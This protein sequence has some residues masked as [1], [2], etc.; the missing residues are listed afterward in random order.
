MKFC[1]F[2]SNLNGERPLSCCQHETKLVVGNAV[3]SQPGKVSLRWRKTPV[4]RGVKQL[5]IVSAASAETSAPKST[6]KQSSSVVGSGIRL[7]DVAVTFKNHQVLKN[8]SWDVKKG[9]RVGLVGVNGAGKTTQLQVITGA[10]LPD[11][12]EVIKAR[13]NMKI[14]Y[15]TQEFDVEP[16]RTVREEFM[17]AFSDQLG[18]MKRQEEVQKGLEECGDDMD[19][20]GQLLDELNELSKVA[21]DLDVNLLDKKIDQMMPELG[22]SLDDNDRLVA[23]YSG[24]WQMRMCLGKI[25]LQEPDLL[26]LDEPTNHLDLDAIGWLESYL[27]E[28]EVPMVIVSH[29][30][31][32]LDALCTKIVET[33]RGVT[34][35]FKGNYSDY[36][37]QKK[38]RVAQQWTAWE[39]QEKELDRQRE[40]VRSLAAGANSGR[41]STAEKAIE[42]M[43]A[44]GTYVEKPFVPRK[45][46]FTF[47][48]AERMGRIAIKIDG[49][50]HG[51]HGRNLF[52]DASLE[53]EKGE[54]VAI[55]GPNGAGKSTL[56]RLIMGQE[57]PIEGEVSMGEHGIVAN[58][59][60]QNQAEALDP[61]KNAIETLQYA[62]PDAKLNDVKALLGKMMFNGAAMEKKAKVLSGGEKARLAMAK[63]MLTEGT[64][65]ILDEP[66]NH[67]DIPTKE[68]LEEAVEQFDGAVIAVSHDRYFLRKIA[69]RVVT[70]ENGKLVDYDGDYNTFLSEN[71]SEKKKMDKLE[72][73]EREAEKSKV[74]AKSK[75]SK[76]QKAALKKEKAK[77]FN[78]TSENKKASKAKN[79]K[80]WN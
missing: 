33:E 28:Q 38:E 3:R 14:A 47:P 68:T 39:K 79:N 76:A 69:T 31:Q 9:E 30:R 37:T 55:I 41:A 16:T 73:R 67:L 62:S 17:S 56:L 7:E 27:K 26:L 58:Y 20:M 25:L 21:V 12:G 54:R 24:G 34:Q 49:L 59:F 13:Q 1:N 2:I 35:T 57:D 61:E 66:T 22:F 40:I 42:K 5:H 43:K 80:R 72:Q 23:S 8:A 29:D 75:M 44:E 4:Q 74:K 48:S 50:T 19:K 46:S 32:F 78:D 6:S 11:S 18:V 45:R 53:I 36:Q 64:L 65:L 63:F 15:L 10:L 77:Q 70:V 51:Y 52:E 60:E 71:K